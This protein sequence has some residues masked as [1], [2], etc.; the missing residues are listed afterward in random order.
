MISGPSV[1]VFGVHVRK[2]IYKQIGFTESL[3]FLCMHM[4]VF[5][6]CMMIYKPALILSILCKVHY[7]WVDTHFLNLVDC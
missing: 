1:C 2:N 3:L 4:R 6:L 7:S 5:D